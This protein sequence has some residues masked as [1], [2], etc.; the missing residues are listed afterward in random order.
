[1]I[2]T[3]QITATNDTTEDLNQVYFPK[4]KQKSLNG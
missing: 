1:M 3:L 2:S 4:I